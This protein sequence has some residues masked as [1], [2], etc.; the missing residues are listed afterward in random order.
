RPFC[1][2]VRERAERDPDFRDA[3]K[4]EGLKVS[5]P[6]FECP[7]CGAR[8]QTDLECYAC[9]TTKADVAKRKLRETRSVFARF[10]VNEAQRVKAANLRRAAAVLLDMAHQIEG[11]MERGRAQ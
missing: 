3:L 1:E 11:R 4:E 2:T 10:P 8:W 9:C 7:E 5:F 6:V